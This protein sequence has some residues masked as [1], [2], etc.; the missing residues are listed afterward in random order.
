M[1]IRQNQNRLNALES[2]SQSVELVLDR[3]A[4]LYRQTHQER[5]QMIETWR[6]AVQTLNNRDESIRATIDVSKFTICLF[7]SLI[8]L[9]ICRK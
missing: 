3:T 2:E 4:H 7:F 5:R 1:A 9:V 6:M 8:Y